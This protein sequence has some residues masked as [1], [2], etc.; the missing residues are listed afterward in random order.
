MVRFLED[1]GVEFLRCEG[2]SDYYSEAKGGKARGRSIETVP[3]DAR[4]LGPWEAKLQPGFLSARRVAIHTVELQ[5]FGLPWRS[6]AGARTIGRVLVRT[7]KARARRQRLLANGASLIANLLKLAVEREIPIW[8]QTPLVDLVVE[9]GAVTGIVV[10]RHGRDVRVRARRGV[11]LSAGGFAHNAE[12]RAKY[13]GDQPNDGRWTS[14]NPGDTGEVI[15]L[16]MAA[17]ATVDLMDEAWWIQTSVLPNGTKLM[18]I[19]ERT[20][21]GSIMVDRGGQRFVNEAASYMEVGKEQ[22]ARSRVADALPCWLVFDTRFRR[23]YP[24][25]MTPPAITPKEW[26]TSGYLHRADTLEDLARDCGIDPDGLR[27]TV[28]RFNEHARR[29]EDPDFHRGEAR[30]DHWYGDPAHEPNPSLG[31]LDKAPYYAVA[32]W[33]GDVGTCGGLLTDEHGRVRREDGSTI[34]GLYATGNTTATVMGR[35][36]LGAGASIG[37]SMVFAFVAARHA[38]AAP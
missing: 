30:Y 32:I 1:L 31:P 29:G 14:A 10:R 35:R 4:D 6:A 11:L 24:F 3:F 13:G 2:Y 28:E 12:M 17:G 27:R 34:P 33:P 5:Q 8:T 15:D 23:R 18:H 19:S 9:D 26:I 20:R 37:S 21:P 16:A 25:V 38:A 7:V 22:Y 36:Y